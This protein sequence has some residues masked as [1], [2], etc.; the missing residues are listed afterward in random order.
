MRIG[1]IGFGSI[2]SELFTR[3]NN[4]AGYEFCAL[5][6]SPISDAPTTLHQ[7][8]THQDLLAFAPD[9]IVE[10][11]GHAAVRAYGVPSLAAGIPLLVASL[12]ALAD[13]ALEAA[14]ST[15]AETNGA[16]LIYPS[17][18]IGG[19]DLLRAVAGNGPTRV[20]YQGVKPPAAWK[21]S[22]AEDMVALDD[23]T[24]S[25]T[26]FTGNGREAALTFPKNANVVAA[27]ALAGPGFDALNV[28]LTADPL[29]EANM[30]SYSVCSDACSYEM[31]I[32]GAASS[33]NARTSLTTVLS[34]A[35]EIRAFAL[36]V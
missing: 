27:L 25:T 33:G 8:R 15:A 14:L 26:F 22:P 3:L 12:G 11:A 10:C 34:I 35:A 23:L 2:G 18:A 17:G 1:L 7:V 24:D 6:R 9:L 30:H 16:R 4:T 28:T 19:L 36:T 20:T 29:A 32:K 13:P 5:T 31:S 21:G